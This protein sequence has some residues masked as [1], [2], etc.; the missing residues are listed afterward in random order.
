MATTN[1]CPHSLGQHMLTP[2]DSNTA[3][4]LPPNVTFLLFTI[5]A[6]HNIPETSNVF[7]TIGFSFLKTIQ[8]PQFIEIYSVSLPMAIVQMMGFN[9]LVNV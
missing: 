8:W 9:W 7:F 6:A 1:H 3:R 5:P 4:R 2:N